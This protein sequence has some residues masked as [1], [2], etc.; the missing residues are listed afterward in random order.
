[1]NRSTDSG[2]N[3]NRLPIR[4]T[5]RSNFRRR[6]VSSL[7]CSCSLTP[8]SLLLVA[9]AAFSGAFIVALLAE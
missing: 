8:L 6:T 7:R 2:L 3:R 9:P 4:T 1:M 5:P